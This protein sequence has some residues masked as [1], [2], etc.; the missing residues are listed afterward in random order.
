MAWADHLHI[1]L[2]LLAR[3]AAQARATCCQTCSSPARL[4]LLLV[5]EALCARALPGLTTRTSNP[6]PRILLPVP[7]QALATC[8][9]NLHLLG[10]Q[11]E[12]LAHVAADATRQYLRVLAQRSRPTDTHSP[13]G[14]HS[15]TFPLAA[16]NSSLLKGSLET[17]PDGSSREAGSDS[18]EADEGLGAGAR[19]PRLPVSGPGDRHDRR[20]LCRALFAW[21]ALDAELRAALLWEGRPTR[22]RPGQLFGSPQ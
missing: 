10:V 19:L 6:C 4:A 17:D 15:A 16:L 22:A 9:H 11:S 8:C 1:P 12:R 7:V 3:Y 2:L 18:F 21:N 13:D 20:Q 5:A 14:S